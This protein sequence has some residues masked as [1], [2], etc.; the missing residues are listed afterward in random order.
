MLYLIYSGM[1]PLLQSHTLVFAFPY[2]LYV[3]KDPSMMPIANFS[4]VQ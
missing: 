3:Y 2:N 1:K 4:Y